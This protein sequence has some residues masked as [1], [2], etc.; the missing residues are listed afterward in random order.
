M[1]RKRNFRRRLQ[2]ATRAVVALLALGL[3]GPQAAA[4]SAFSID[5]GT[6]ANAMAVPPM[7]ER[8]ERSHRII[9]GAQ[10]ALPQGESRSA[11]QSLR[12]PATMPTSTSTVVPRDPQRSVIPAMAEPYPAH[13]RPQA[14]RLFKEL[15]TGFHK[16]ERELGVPQGDAATAV[17]AFLTGSYIAYTGQ[18]VP[19]EYFRPLIE[20][21]RQAIAGNPQFTNATAAEK[22][23]MYEHLAIVGMFMATTHQAL[24]QQPNAEIRSRMREAGRQQLESFLGTRAERVALGPQ[25]LSIR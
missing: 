12:A 23:Q 19:D 14:Q 20:Q 17:A 10:S 8:L 1:A 13:A 3:A 21:M 4:Q 7:V 9:F 6:F 16:L 5:P 15:L 24:Q 11:R 18:E 2:A 25:G 22:Q